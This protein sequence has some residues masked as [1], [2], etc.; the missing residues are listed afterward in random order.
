MSKLKIRDDSANYTATVIKLP[1]KQPVPGLDNLVKVEVFGNECLVGKDSSIERLYLFFPAGTQLSHNFLSK[2]NLYRD[3]A[4]NEDKNQKG[5]FEPNGRVKGIKLRGIVSNGFVIPAESLCNII[6]GV[7]VN[8][9][10]EFNEFN[11]ELI[12]QK[13]FPKGIQTPG[14]PKGDKQT[15]I[16]NKLADLMIPGQFRFHVETAH[17][18]KNLHLINPNDILVITDKWHG[19][20]GILS[21]V[22]ANR[23]L[24]RLQKLWNKVKC[25]PK[26]EARQLV[27]IYSSGKPK[28]NLPKGVE[29]SWTNTGVDYYTSNIWKET[30]DRY[31]TCIE[32]G[33]SIYGEIV[34]FTSGGAYIQKG[35][36]YGC[37]SIP[38]KIGTDGLCTCDA[39]TK[40]PNGRIG[41]A[42]RCSEAELPKNNRFI[43]YR[44]TYTKP[45]GEFIEFSWQ[46][47]KDYCKKYNLEH[48]KEFYFG[49]AMDINKG[50]L[51][52]TN[53]VEEWRNALL[54]QLQNRYNLE[55]NCKH[56]N[57]KV[58]A[59]GIVLRVDGHL[60]SYNVYKL[61]SKLF[62]LGE[63]NSEEINI[64]DN[65]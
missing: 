51:E 29:G 16:N 5:F 44:I 59:K 2:N 53:N 50:Y 58:P 43:V 40:C 52:A 7:S 33:I 13:Y 55:M 3:I 48:V 25:L 35:Y 54:Y 47:I 38:T 41:S 63:S 37:V 26:F 4:L 32:E 64:E 56:C 42:M 15:K 12:C 1:V 24:T 8:V 27:Y 14:L 6:N 28:S 22:Y 49:K 60:N 39:A 10:D 45:N 46:Q 30:L 34:G 11:G 61:K 31:K 19:S 36:D 9:G 18:A 57:N 17:L 62:I 20:S 23:K 65:Q 21:R